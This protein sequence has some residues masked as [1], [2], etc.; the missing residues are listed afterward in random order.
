VTRAGAD[1][2]LR[3]VR[4]RS[5]LRSWLEANHASSP[6]VHL[7]IGKKGRSATLLTYDD[8]V[9]E[10]LAFGWIDSTS[11]HL[12]ADRHTV[13]F[14]RRNR[15]SQWS[16]SNKARV[17]RLTDAGLMAPAGRAAVDSAKADGSW[18]LFDDVEDLVVPDDLAQ[19]LRAVPAAAAFFD[20]LPPSQRKLALYWVAS[21]KRPETRSTRVSEVVRAAAEGRRPL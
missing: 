5:E 12:D 13:L 20:A 10:A 17:A 19:A 1:L 3:E 4:D 18:T 11:H 2:P 8:A 9:E 14:T 21:A 7:A 6:G 15:G 16:R